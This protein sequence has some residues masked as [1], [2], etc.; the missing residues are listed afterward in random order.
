MKI[1]LTRLVK[2]LSSCCKDLYGKEG[3]LTMMKVR[4]FA[5][6]VGCTPQNVYLHLRNY[7]AELEG[8]T[9]KGRRGIMLDDYACEFIRGVM[10]PKEI[11]A[12]AE[13]TA[14][15]NKLRGQ[16]LKLGMENTALSSKLATVE[17]ERDR[18]LLEAGHHQRALA[19]SNEELE[20][21]KEDAQRARD[22]ATAAGERMQEAMVGLDHANQ[23]ALEA[24]QEAQQL[25]DEA[26][27][28]R[29][30]LEA[31]ESRLEALKGRNWLDRL[32]RKGE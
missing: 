12:D 9:E 25:R 16:L 26:Q 4:E 23:M 11:S 24:R 5:E 28:T 13:V 19:A 3:V 31:A 14:E 20:Q 32:L 29:E 15:L 22:E 17:A 30:A 27:A 10:Y 18:A 8:H 1:T 21:A 2:L 7:A 6:K